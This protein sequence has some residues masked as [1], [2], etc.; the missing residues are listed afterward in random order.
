MWKRITFTIVVLWP[1]PSWAGCHHYSVW[2]YKFPQKCTITALYYPKIK[3]KV[4]PILIPPSPEIDNMQ[5]L[6][7]LLESA[8]FIPDIPIAPL[9]EI[10]HDQE[11]QRA[12]DE[13]KQKH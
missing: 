3:L 2:N 9:L 13:L 1:M 6:K 8:T 5:R 4:D 12:I 7:T 11:R 10:F